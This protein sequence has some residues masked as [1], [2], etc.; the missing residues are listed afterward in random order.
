MVAGDWRRRVDA[1]SGVRWRRVWS[2]MQ[3]R[4][5]LPL[6]T[7]LAAQ[8]QRH[9]D[10]WGPDRVHVV[11]ADDPALAVTR[12]AGI[13]G[14]RLGQAPLAPA[15]PVDTD[16]LRLVNQLL[17]AKG[18]R[19]RRPSLRRPWPGGFG[20]PAAQLDWAVARGSALAGELR[21]GPWQVHGD[22]AVV[23]PS[24]DAALARAVAPNQTLTLAL[25]VLG[26]LE[27]GE[28]WPGR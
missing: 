3:A 27:G 10:L 18:S 2:V 22:P 11:L 19:A 21:D 12:A 17:A 24:T 6:G 1:G 15:H 9:T 13:L 20:A 14:V 16:L 5:H 8:A 4:D 7:D 23:V 28:P 25:E 26:R